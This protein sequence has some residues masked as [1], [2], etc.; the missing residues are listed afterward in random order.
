MDQIGQRMKQLREEKHLTLQQLSDITGVTVAAIS[1]Y[2]N[3]Q[4][5]PRSNSIVAIANALNTSTDYLL[6]GQGANDLQEEK[7]R[8]MVEI[9]QLGKDTGEITYRQADTLME[10]AK[11]AAL[12][13]DETPKKPKED[14]S[15]LL[16]LLNLARLDRLADE[17]D[18][19]Q[20][21]KEAE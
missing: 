6:T 12:G 15:S 2:E 13:V 8:A 21:S 5:L 18:A 19:K 17:Q 7:Y 9:I 20:R 11:S 3:D 16:T 14:A 10:M 1:R 4:R